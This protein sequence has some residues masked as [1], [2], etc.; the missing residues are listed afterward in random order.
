MFESPNRSTALCLSLCP[1]VSEKDGTPASGKDM[2]F[3]ASPHESDIFS[4]VQ[5]LLGT[6]LAFEALPEDR[7]AQLHVDH[8][9]LYS[10]PSCLPQRGDVDNLFAELKRN[11]STPIPA[12]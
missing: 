11:G 4:V 1:K 5:A 6:F 2:Y 8:V 10:R 7:R 12:R 3:G 9:M